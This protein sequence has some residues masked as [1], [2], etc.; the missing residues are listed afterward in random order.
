MQAVLR[1]PAEL[2]TSDLYAVSGGTPGN[3]KGHAYG[4]DK[5]SSNTVEITYAPTT[6]IIN[7]VINSLTV[8]L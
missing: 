4:H 2:T 6:D 3:G 7:Y 1:E 5:N 8:T